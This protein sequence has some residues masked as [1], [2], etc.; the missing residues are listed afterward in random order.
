[1]NSRDDTIAALA[2]PSGVSALAVIRI[3]GK[4]TS[5]LATRIFG[6]TPPPRTVTRLDYRDASSGLIDDVLAT[7]F[8]GPNSYTGEDT[9]EISSHGSPYIARRILDDL[10]ARGCRPADPG[11]FTERAFLNGKIDLAQAEAVMDVIH[12][13]GE[14][15]LAAAHY[16]LRGSLGRHLQ[17]LVDG[18]LAA[19]ARVEAY[20]DF[21]EE[22]LPTEDTDL[23][24]QEIGN[25][26]R[27]TSRLLATEKA[28]TWLREGIGTVILGEP[29]AGKSSLLNRLVGR[30]R[31]LVSADPGTTRDFIEERVVMGPHWLRLVDTAGLNETP[32]SIERLGIEKTFE[33]VENADLVILL[34]DANLPTPALPALLAG[35]LSS[36]NTLVVLNKIDLLRGPVVA[37]APD[38]FTPLLISALTAD[39]I[40]ELE[41]AIVA[42]AD[43]LQRDLGDEFV[44]I[45]ARHARALAEVRSALEDALANL[46]SRG[47]VELLASDLRTALDAIGQISGRV[48]NERMLDALFQTF[49]IGK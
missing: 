49:C 35:K 38:G 21:P 9:L 5:G 42:L 32:G 34:L 20:I 40:G 16:Q 30:D 36:A 46:A 8:I 28:G 39:G 26:L 22:D 13:R 43:R 47:P 15:A 19:L 1:M 37:T 10:F 18:L 31:A 25:V 7:F 14:R 6:R 24:A 48:D 2:T 23:V 3:S 17:G 11:E 44:T 12:A 27:G 33:Q 41:A 29:N 45:N 4:D